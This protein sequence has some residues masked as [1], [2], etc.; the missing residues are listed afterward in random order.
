MQDY[1]ICGGP[2]M[3]GQ[4]CFD[5]LIDIRKLNRIINFNRDTGI[6][7]V[8]AG[9]EWPQLTGVIWRGKAAIS[10]PGNCTKTNRRRS[11]NNFRNNCGQRAW[12]RAENETV[13]Q[14][15]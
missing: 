6:I 2:A 14:Q 3:G 13:Y 15:R 10:E 12:S 4:N 7:E 8:E 11:A 1:L 5:T 9:I